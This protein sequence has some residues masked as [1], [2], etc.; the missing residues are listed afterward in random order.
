MSI[1]LIYVKLA[2]KN[3][4]LVG[5]CSLIYIT[6]VKICLTHTVHMRYI[7]LTNDLF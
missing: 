1:D 3:G 4:G 7:I 2:D 5:L 6:L